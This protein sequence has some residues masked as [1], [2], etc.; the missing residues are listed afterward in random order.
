MSNRVTSPRNYV[1]ESHPGADSSTPSTW[2]QLPKMPEA[3]RKAKRDAKGRTYIT[4]QS[5]RTELYRHLCS[6]AQSI[7]WSGK[8]RTSVPMQRDENHKVKFVRTVWWTTTVTE[9]DL[10]SAVQA[11]AARYAARITA[12]ERQSFRSPFVW[13]QDV[14]R[15]VEDAV[16]FA[17]TSW[18]WT[19]LEAHYQAASRGG[20]GHKPRSKDVTL[21]MVRD[22][23]PE[24][25]GLTLAQAAKR[26][27]TWT[28]TTPTG[29]ELP[30]VHADTIRARLVEL[31]WTPGPAR[32]KPQKF[33]WT[34][35]DQFDGI[36]NPQIAAELGV[37]LSTVKRLQAQRK[38]AGSNDTETKSM[39]ETAGSNDT[40]TKS[41]PTSVEPEQPESVEPDMH[42]EDHL[43]EFY[44]LFRE[45]Q[46]ELDRRAR[47]EVDISAVMTAWADELLAAA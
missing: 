6:I 30:K 18:D 17:M 44:R 14:Q 41:V 42:Q 13:Q 19:V 24:V 27:A 38:A 45:G 36:T 15:A 43:E 31:G 8:K 33:S 9:A 4:E 22:R 21:D 3:P 10:L 16:A 1:I 26:M 39:S 7:L 23:L 20:R 5:M 28:W 12:T 2:G 40:E 34:V 37:S 25:D 32:Q 35:L 29:R 11:Y 46:D 47:G